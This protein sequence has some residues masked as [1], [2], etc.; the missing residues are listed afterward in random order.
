[1][2]EK[3]NKEIRKLSLAELLDNKMK[4]LYKAATGH[5]VPGTRCAGDTNV[6]M[7]VSKALGEYL[8]SWCS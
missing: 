3:K 8:N 1:M 6:K 7:Q 4:S 2:E 5:L